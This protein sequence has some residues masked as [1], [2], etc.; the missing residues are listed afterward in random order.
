MY[1]TFDQMLKIPKQ[2][3]FDESMLLTLEQYAQTTGQSFASV[4]RE[5]LS[6][7]LSVMKARIKNSQ[8]KQK[9]SSILD[10]YG[11]GKSPYKRKFSARE[12][13]EIVAK[14]IGE[15]AAKEGLYD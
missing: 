8:P 12:E 10:F 2:I 4:V 15:N 7:R 9:K 6:E 13:R 3:Y 5:N 1:V 14:I 11:A